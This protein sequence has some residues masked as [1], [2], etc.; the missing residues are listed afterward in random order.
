[1]T[2]RSED[3]LGPC[4]L[5]IEQQRQIAA[6]QSQVATESLRSSPQRFSVDRHESSLYVGELAPEVND[7]ILRQYFKGA[8][9]V[10][11]CR[12]HISGK[13]LGYAYVNFNRA[14]DCKSTGFWDK[15]F[16]I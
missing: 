16:N 15:T 5:T 13:S 9:S 14:E 1:M 2:D 4:G 8:K 6:I 11:V 10:H 12:D 3:S 7:E